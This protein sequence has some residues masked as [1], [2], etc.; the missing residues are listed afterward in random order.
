MTE[1]KFEELLKLNINDKVEK[2]KSGKTELTYLSW[3]FAVSEMEKA[4]PEWEY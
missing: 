3:A 4:Y 1:S 2:K